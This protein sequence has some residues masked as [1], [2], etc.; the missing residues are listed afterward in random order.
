MNSIKISLITLALFFVSC[1]QNS[2]VDVAENDAKIEIIDSVVETEF[3]DNSLQNL[4]NQTFSDTIFIT[5]SAAIFLQPDSVETL[6]L[7]KELGEDDYF[8]TIDDYNFYAMTA[9]DLFEKNKIEVIDT[10]KNFVCFL[11][12]SKKQYC[13][14]RVKNLDFGL[15]FFRSDTVPIEVDLIDF[16]IQFFNKN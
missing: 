12:N 16:D 3:E 13:I 2:K 6:K 7:I 10:D 14:K 11:L 4:N 15:L 1:T 9:K 8:T 5:N